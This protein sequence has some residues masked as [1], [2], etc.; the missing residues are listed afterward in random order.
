MLNGSVISASSQSWRG[1]PLISTGRPVSY[2]AGSAGTA[3][4]GQISASYS[5]P[6]RGGGG[7]RG[8]LRV[9][10]VT[11]E[12]GAER[13]PQPGDRFEHGEDLQLGPDRGDVGRVRPGDHVLQQRAVGY[14]TG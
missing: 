6:V 8:H 4:V 14:A 12:I 13:D 7:V 1:R 3:K 5:S 9:H 10:V 11:A 2:S